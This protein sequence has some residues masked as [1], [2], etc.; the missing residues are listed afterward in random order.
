[1]AESN[2][3]NGTLIK[4]RPRP[5]MM[6][7]SRGRTSLVTGLDGSVERNRAEEGL[8][9]YDTRLISRYAWL[10]N[11]KAPKLSTASNVDQNSWVAYY[12]QAPRGCAKTP[13]HECDPLQETVE[14]RISREVGEGMHEHVHVTNHTQI[15]APVSLR[16]NFEISFLS[17]SE[18]ETGRKQHGKL[19]IRRS[20]PAAGVWDLMAHYSAQ[21]RYSHQ[22]NIGIAHL[23]RGIRLRI[24][25]TSSIP[26][27]SRSMISFEFILAP[28]QEWHACLSWIAYIDGRQLPLTSRCQNENRSGWDQKKSDFLRNA[29]SFAFNSSPGLTDTV[30]RV[31]DRARLD[32]ELLRLHDFEFRGDQHD[33]Q[34]IA[35]A[36]GIPTY[37]EVFGRDMEASGWQASLVSA[38]FMCGALNVLNSKCAKEENDWRDAQPG[39]L[40]HEIHSD[41]LSVLNYRPQSLYF[42][43]VSSSFLF[44]ILV[45]EL[46]HWTGD[47]DGIRKYAETAMNAIHWADKYSLDSTG[48]YR[49][50]TRSEQGVKNQGWKDSNDAIVYPDGSQVEA[51]IGTCEMQGFMYS[52]KLCFSEIMFRLGHIEAARKL[53]DQAEDLKKRFNETFWMEDEGYLALGIDKNGNLIRSVASDAGQCMLTGI[54]DENRVQRVAKRM[55]RADMFSGWGVRTLSAE[56]PAYNPFSYHRGSVWPVIS[57]AFVMAFSRYGLQEKMSLL[58][59]AFFE[60][61]TLFD[62]DR[63]PE[64][65][66]G[67]RRSPEMPFPGL[68]T[69]ADYPQAW[70]ASAPFTVIRAMLG[71][72]PYAPARI[73]FVDPHLPE[74]LPEIAVENLHVAGATVTLRFLR[75]EDGETDYQVSN[76]NGTVHVIRQPSPWSL[77]S[78]WAERISE[79]VESLLPQRRAS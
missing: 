6:Q 31:L 73:L 26:K 9:V 72:C 60:S 59:K 16:L 25:N 37:Q 75:N 52:A 5:D 14:L 1:M 12:I 13:A 17:Q 49:Y 58:A 29:T 65:Y 40:P 3:N 38:A 51:P 54:L 56:H 77:I 11:R 20:E 70:S 53:F 2:K 8:Y 21:H 71:I 41:P 19:E 63:L 36:A 43:S 10:L 67:H 46:Y 44:P 30:H 15:A 62:H 47:L 48:F 39:R 32:L 69:R 4:I 50:I 79:A 66:G 35:L 61:A 7:T 45:S 64:V 57:A 42:G 27:I 28:H 18:V 55:M 74:W 78:G 34:G 68:Y 23:D 33:A 24:E 22:G 76:V